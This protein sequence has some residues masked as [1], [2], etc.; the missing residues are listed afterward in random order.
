MSNWN[1]N[2]LLS[3][4]KFKNLQLVVL[5][6]YKKKLP[7]MLIEALL[8]MVNCESKLIIKCIVPQ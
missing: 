6:I 3:L 2:E 1:E 7:E 8:S 4:G 5:K